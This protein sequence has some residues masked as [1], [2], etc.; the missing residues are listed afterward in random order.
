MRAQQRAQSQP[1]T[2]C[3][4]N[5]P[6]A[7]TAPEQIGAKAPSRLTPRVTAAAM[8]NPTRPLPVP[9]HG[10]ARTVCRR[11][12]RPSRGAAQR[13]IADRRRPG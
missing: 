8:E 13:V 3:T 4:E 2:H 11:T 9:S 7:A 10:V 5:P 12:G 6:W 1:H